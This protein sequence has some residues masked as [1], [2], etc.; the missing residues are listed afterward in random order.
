[1]RVSS[2]FGLYQTAEGKTLFEIKLASFEQVLPK[3]HFRLGFLFFH[4]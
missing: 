4:F 1:M 2:L 3:G